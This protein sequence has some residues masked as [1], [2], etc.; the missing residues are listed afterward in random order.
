MQATSTNQNWR[1]SISRIELGL[2]REAGG[3][4]CRE[5]G[6]HAGAEAE[7]CDTRKWVVRG[8]TDG[9]RPPGGSPG[10][11]AEMLIALDRPLL[12]SRWQREN[13]ALLGWC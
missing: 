8:D 1:A 11:Q 2:K 9:A 13:R 12:P 10:S 4:P 7:E 6:L 5:P 3:T